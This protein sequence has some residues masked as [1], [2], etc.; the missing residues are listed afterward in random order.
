MRTTGALHHFL[1]DLEAPPLVAV[2]LVVLAFFTVVP[3]V[4]VAVFEASPFL[5]TAA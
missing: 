3:P 4:V 2:L 1:D 5:A